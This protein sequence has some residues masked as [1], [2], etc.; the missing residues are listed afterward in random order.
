MGIAAELG[1]SADLRE[2]GPQ[3][4]DEVASHIV[5]LDHGEGLQG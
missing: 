1:Q 5:I 2:R 4:A 3:I